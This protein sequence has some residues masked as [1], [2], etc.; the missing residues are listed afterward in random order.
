MT[1]PSAASPVRIYWENI[2]FLAL[3]HLA[4]LAGIVYAAAAHFSL[5]TLGLAAGW[6]TLCMLSTT[7]GYHRLF[8]HRTYRA[9]PAVNWGRSLATSRANRWCRG[10]LN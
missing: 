5:A 1:R 8:A 2:L 10:C 9:S 7:G 6:L 4:G 3:T